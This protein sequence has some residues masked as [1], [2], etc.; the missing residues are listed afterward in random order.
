MPLWDRLLKTK[1]NYEYELD[2]ELQDQELRAERVAQQAGS[3]SRGRQPGI[4]ESFEM[5]ER[6]PEPPHRVT[7]R[8][9][10]DLIVDWIV[11]D[12]QAFRVS[13]SP[14]FQY[15]MKRAVGFANFRLVN[16]PIA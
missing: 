4:R 16:C 6:E 14:D 12:L 2:E 15:M 13:E 11:F 1:C 3:E 10:E 8:E 5:S 9:W 7:P